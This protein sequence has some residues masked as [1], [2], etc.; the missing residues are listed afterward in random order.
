MKRTKLKAKEIKDIN[1][2]FTLLCKYYRSKNNLSTN[3][4]AKKLN[5]SK[6]MV[7]SFESLNDVRGP[8]KSY[9]TIMR[10][11]AG[12]DLSPIAFIKILEGK[13]NEQGDTN[14]LTEE[15]SLKIKNLSTKSVGHLLFILESK[16]VEK[17]LELSSKLTSKKNEYI[18]KIGDFLKAPINTTK[19][20]FSVFDTLTKHNEVK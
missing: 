10:M 5:C 19:S 6:S 18:N 1:K 7:E 15:I 4:M 2:R 3:E 16:N 20:I 13:E 9:E 11:A 8:A 14:E 12:F 17:I